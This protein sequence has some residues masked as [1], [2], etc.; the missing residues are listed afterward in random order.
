MPKAAMYTPEFLASAL[1][2]E[3]AAKKFLTVCNMRTDGEAFS[4]PE[5]SYHAGLHGVITVTHSDRGVVLR[6]DMR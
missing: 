6:L 5:V 3:T 4:W 1:E 2:F